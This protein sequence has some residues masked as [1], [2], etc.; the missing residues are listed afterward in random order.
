MTYAIRAV[1][2]HDWRVLREVRLQALA[3]APT[4]F[5]TTLGEAHQFT[6]DRWRERARG[7]AT[8]RQFLAFLDGDAVGIAG[9]FDEGDGSAEIVS[10]WV[11]PEHRARGVATDLTMAAIDFAI[12]AGIARITL[13]VTGG[14]APARG[15]YQRLGFTP[16]GRRQPLPSDPSL[17]EHEMEIRAAPPVL[18]PFAPG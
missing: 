6:E 7:S 5:G 4:A 3:D 14:N 11:R 12:A 18:A 13:W 9:V 2:E 17:D 8:S 10:V 1:F 16:T 15:L